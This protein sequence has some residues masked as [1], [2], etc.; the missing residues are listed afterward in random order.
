M[1]VLDRKMFKK[2]NKADVRLLASG[3]TLRFAVEASKKLMDY[4]SIDT[5]IIIGGIMSISG[6]ILQLSFGISEVQT[7][8]PVLIAFAISN[9]GTGMLMSNCFYKALNS[10]SSF[11]KY[12]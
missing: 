10:K 8:L 4:I 2:E 6:G 7:P 3:L 9:F 1:S 12:E 5:I 11:C